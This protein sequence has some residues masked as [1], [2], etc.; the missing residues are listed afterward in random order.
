MRNA[1]LTAFAAQGL[2]LSCCTKKNEHMKKNVLLLLMALVAC[3]WVFAAD[4][5]TRSASATLAGNAVASANWTTNPDGITGLGDVTITSADNL[6]ILNGGVATIINSGTMMVAALNI[7]SG[8]T[9]IHNNNNWASTFTIVGTLTWN[10][11]IRTLQA[12]SGGSNFFNANGDVTGITAVHDLA[13]NR[14][15]YLG[16]TNRTISL[17]QLNTGVISASNISIGLLINSASRRLSG[18]CKLYS[19]L[20]FQAATCTLDLNGF[21]LQASTIKVPNLTGTRLIKGHPS[22][23]LTISGTSATLPATA[24]TLLTFDPTA[25]VLNELKLNSEYLASAA[26]PVTVNGNLTVNKLTFGSPTG[27]AATRILQVNGDFAL[28]NN[29]TMRVQAG[30]PSAGTNHDQVN[31]TGNISIGTGTTLKIDFI[32][33]YGTT[34]QPTLVFANSTSGSVAGTFTNV[35]K[36]AG[37]VGNVNYPGSAV[38][39]QLVSTPPPGTPPPA[40][41]VVFNPDLPLLPSSPAIEA[42]IDLVVQRFSDTYLGVTATTATAL[43]NAEAAYNNLGIVVDGFNISATT[44]VTN[45]GQVS[46]LRTFAQHLKF[47]PDDENIFTKALNTVWLVSDRMCKGTFAPDY[48]QYSYRDFGRSAILIPRIKDNLHVRTLFEN[49]M[50]QQN[51]FDYFWEANYNGGINDDHVGNSGN[52]TMAYVKWLDTPEERYRH[53]RAFKRFVENFASYTPGT[54]EGIKPDGSGFHHWI[55]YPSYMYNLNAGADF[56]WWFRGTSFQISSDGYLRLRDA[57]MAQLMFTNDN[58]TRFL[59]MAGRKPEEVATTISRFSFRNM[60]LA[61]GEI[62]GTGTS[63]PVMATTYNR[64]WGNLG[65]FTAFGNSTVAPFKDGFFSFNH[66]MAGIYRKD[67]WVA[68]QKGFSNNMF[69]SEIYRDA[70]RFGRYQSY[71]ALNIIYPGNALNGNG[72]DVTN[73][74]WNFTPGATVIRLPWAKLHGERERIDELQQKRFVGSLSFMNKGQDYLQRIHGTYGVFAMDFQERTGEGFGATYSSNNHNSTFAWKKSVFTFDNIMISLGSNIGNNDAE[75]NTLTTLYQRKAIAGKEQVTAN[76]TTLS[77]ASYSNNYGSSGNNW[78]VDNFGTGF[79]VFAGSG[80]VRLTRGDQRTPQ[81]NVLWANQ[82]VDNNPVGNYAIGYIDHGKAPSGAAYEYITMPNA[83]AADMEN[84][85]SQISAGNKPYT[86]HR[87][88]AVAHIV[89]YKPNASANSIFGYSF[90]SALSGIDNGGLVTSVDFPSLV[91]AQYDNT[92]KSFR[93]AVTNPDL[94]FNSRQFTPSITRQINV[95]IKGTNWQVTQSNVSATVTGVANGETTIRFTTVDG[96]PVE[97]VLSRVLTPQTISFEP[98]AEQNATG[99]TIELAATASSGLP[100][101]YTSSNTE[102]ATVNGNMLSIVGFGTSTITATQQGDDIFAAATPV[103]QSLS[104]VDNLPP[105]V[106]APAAQAFCSSNTDYQVPALVASDNTGVGAITYTITGATQR[107]GT[108]ADASGTFAIGVSTITWTVSDNYNNSATAST[109]VEVYSP[110]QVTVPDVFA[111][112]PQATTANT[113]YIGFGPA[114]LSLAATANGGTPAYQ[115]AWNTG[116]NTSSID[117]GAAGTYTVQVTDA[118]N[119]KATASITLQ[120]VDVRC[121]NKNDKVMICHNGQ[122][123]CV[124]PAAVMAHL[125]H[126]DTMG[127]CPL[128]QAGAAYGEDEVRIFPNPVRDNFSVVLPH[129]APNATGTFY[130]ATGQIVLSVRIS[131]PQ[132][133]LSLNGLAAGTYFLVINNGGETTRHTIIKQ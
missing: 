116:A 133:M 38:A 121:G 46:F 103:E 5:Y 27:D 99:T 106:T 84:L 64:V 95:T 19:P 62:L 21:D 67:G 48:N 57:L 13:S 91:M 90:F 61:G 39:F 131:N 107:S 23:S 42:E 16:G 24:A 110:V 81:H 117:A 79:Y 113:L 44:T 89:E 76:G 73:W 53:M 86:V 74:D 130:S 100:V 93:I 105:V 40:C 45:Y 60:A 49:L 20:I 54:H 122:P 68:V 59:T 127:S 109:T 118:N 41:P 70:N 63:D 2:F 124:A 96:M 119:C 7:N 72:Y 80:E 85:N 47:N 115:Y 3:Q 18:D 94:G 11:R 1:M 14:G 120:T 10:G 50:I 33:D 8:G 15:V 126:G 75:H 43:A 97:M 55:S 17:T 6:F 30:G 36:T 123:L 51:N 58:A 9:I 87:K 37:Y 22:S 52:I 65:A 102:V 12:A 29:G 111:L 66:S 82:N 88:D 4:Y 104:V 129:L 92:Q 25:A 31:A 32:N 69:G 125:N 34:A 101:S 26:G 98:L 77:S 83:T 35:Q 112:S 108:G 28:A 78:L 114:T 132:Q 128:K 71:G 56:I